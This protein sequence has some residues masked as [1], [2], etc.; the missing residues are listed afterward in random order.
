MAPASRRSRHLALLRGI[1]VSG[2]NKLPMA[3]L[4]RIFLDAGAQDVETYIQSGNV[5][6]SAS[7]AV[8]RRVPA[9]V[10]TAIADR[11]GYRVPVVMRTASELRRTATRNP[12]VDESVDPKGLH[13]A[14]LA[15]KPTK[16]R[17]NGLDPDRSP[18]DRFVVRGWDIYLHCPRGLA[19]SKLTNAYFDS[20]LQTT[21]TL[22]N[23]RTVTRLVE[24]LD[25]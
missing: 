25:G 8:A 4:T 12:F 1:N 19:R 24:M 10:H 13:V 23:W 11:F 7:D 21:S 17:C 22:R 15:T 9:L 6:F 18:P 2:K 3:E 14:F 20:R 5:T 16:A